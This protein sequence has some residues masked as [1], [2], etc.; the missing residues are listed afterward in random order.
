LKIDIFGEKFGIK[1]DIISVQKF[2]EMFESYGIKGVI[3]G[4]MVYSKR[5]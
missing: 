4:H 5:D 1:G 2:E 3:D